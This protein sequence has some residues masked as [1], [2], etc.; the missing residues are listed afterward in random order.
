MR[1]VGDGSARQ[2]RNS[3]GSTPASTLPVVEVTAAPTLRTERWFV[4]TVL[5]TLAGV[6]WALVAWQAAGM[7]MTQKRLDLTMGMAAPLFIVMWTA[8]MVAMM[9]PASAP[10]VLAF[11][12]TQAGKRADGGPY[13]PTAFFL[14]PY[15]VVWTTFGVVGFV[16]ARVVAAVAGD[17]MWAVDN[18]PRIA[19]GLLVAAG[20]YQLT[21]LKRV[22]LARCRTPLSFMLS[23]WRE[24]RRGAM[25]MGLR[26]GLYC[27]GCCWVLFLVLLPLGVMNVVAMVAVAA[28]VFAE[29]VLPRGELVARAAAVGLLA[30]GVVAML[31]P[32]ALPT[33]M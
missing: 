16:T 31:V 23:Y 4:F 7:G 26:H 33:V 6:G 19:G 9:F 1:V 12:R 8:M 24:G 18:L 29:K 5:L 3:D 2:H 14:A 28:L 25:S 10:M 13:V 22:C 21:P 15:V 32:R 20:V 30:Y 27:L 17:S 11:A